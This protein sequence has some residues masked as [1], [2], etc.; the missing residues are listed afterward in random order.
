MTVV[1]AMPGAVA[2]ESGKVAIARDPAAVRRV[3]AAACAASV[4]A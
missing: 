3:V 1:A 4:I 2:Q